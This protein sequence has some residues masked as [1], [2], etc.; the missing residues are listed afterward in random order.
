MFELDDCGR[1]CH[2]TFDLT[3]GAWEHNA[4]VTVQMVIKAPK[5]T[6]VLFDQNHDNLDSQCEAIKAFLEEHSN[7]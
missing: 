1:E 4:D 3:K 5:G 6:M 7:D 2:L